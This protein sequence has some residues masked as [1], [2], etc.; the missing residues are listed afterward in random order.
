MRPKW[1]FFAGSLILF[2]GVVSST[3]FSIFLINF[4][5]FILRKHYGPMYQYKLQFILSNFP[6]WILII[7]VFGIIIGIKLL[8]EYDF[9]YK[10]NFLLIVGGY[11]LAIIFSAFIIDFFNLNKFFYGQGWRKFYYL[12]E[13]RDFNNFK[14][15][16]KP[17]FKNNYWRFENN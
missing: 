2:I 9:S 1:Y 12:K 3:V 7:A 10:K 17:G 14:K 5:F 8:K 4:L 11:I 15:D 16:F 13:K 6:W